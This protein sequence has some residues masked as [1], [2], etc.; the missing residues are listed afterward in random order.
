MKTTLTAAGGLALVLA[1]GVAWAKP[2]AGSVEGNWLAS[3]GA[4]TV[5]IAPCPGQTAN[6]CGTFVGLRKPNGPDGRPARDVNNPNP[7]LKSRPMMGMTFLTGFKPAG[8]GRWT[9]GKIY[10]P[11]D[12]KT[13]NSKM[14]LNPNG[15]LKVE[16]CV[17]V[18]CKAQTWTRAS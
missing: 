16:G 5:R 10:N 2:P 8:P 6:L 11:E 1:A 18:L 7:A 14:T 15:T 9:G 12:G 4:G 3:G 13:Y 17:L